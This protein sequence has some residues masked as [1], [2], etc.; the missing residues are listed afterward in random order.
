MAELKEMGL[1]WGEAQH[2]AKDR[3]QWSFDNLGSRTPQWQFQSSA[4]DPLVEINQGIQVFD[5]KYQLT[6]DLS[7]GEYHLLIPNVTPALSGT[8]DCSLLGSTDYKSAELL[9]LGSITFSEEPIDTIGILG[10][11]VQLNCSFNDFDRG[12]ETLLWYKEKPEVYAISL[13]NKVFK[14]GHYLVDE[15]GTGA[16][17]L[18]IVNTNVTHEGEYRCEAEVANLTSS[19]ELILMDK[20][21]TCDVYQGVTVKAG[22]NTTFNCSVHKAVPPGEL[23]WRM[24]GDIVSTGGNSSTYSWVTSFD[25]TQ[26][27]ATMV[28]GLE[29][30]T[31][32]EPL[33]C[34]NTI[35]MDVQYTLKWA[36]LSPETA[37]RVVKLSKATLSSLIVLLLTLIQKP[38]TSRG[39]MSMETWSVKANGWRST[40]STE[41]RQMT[42]IRA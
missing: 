3:E 38:R 13:N 2:A 42:T 18:R 20:H 39:L 23:M 5:N 1:T 35:V 7:K 6:G 31:L 17:S 40:P 4:G 36:L 8:Y 9:V 26:N 19:A 10:D 11:E 37:V 30:I 32:S 14:E 27:N 24:D 33:A 21:P 29:Y 28:C 25:R 15:F 16:Y 12:S 34:E 22:D 41:T